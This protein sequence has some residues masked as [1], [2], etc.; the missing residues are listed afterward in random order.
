MRLGRQEAGKLEAQK[1]GRQEGRRIM[2][3]CD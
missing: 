3:R 1:A 2:E